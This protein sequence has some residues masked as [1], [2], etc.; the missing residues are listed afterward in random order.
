MNRLV[1]LSLGLVVLSGCSA[2]HIVSRVETNPLPQVAEKAQGDYK[3]TWVDP[4]TLHLRDSWLTHSLLSLGYTAFHAKLHY[5]DNRLEST[6]YLKT[7]NLDTF[8]FS[9]YVDTG[10]GAWGLLL[11]PLIRSE[12]N[13]I[14]DWA[15]VAQDDRT[16]TYRSP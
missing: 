9:V 14:L 12:M 15:G 2:T 8:Y 3:V 13:E 10:K 1:V 4:T 7:N 11:K 16:E 5:A 6:F